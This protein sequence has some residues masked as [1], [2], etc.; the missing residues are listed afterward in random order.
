M[1]ATRTESRPFEQHRFLGRMNL[2]AGTPPS[3]FILYNHVTDY[4]YYGVGGRTFAPMRE[5]LVS[6]LSELGYEIVAIYNS[7]EGMLF[8]EPAMEQRYR[9]VTTG[10]RR[11]NTYG[12]RS[13]TAP[14]TAEAANGTDPGLPQ[15]AL[16]QTGNQIIAGLGA[17]L[18]Q[19][20]R[21]AEQLVRAAVIVERV[22]NLV[23]SPPLPDDRQL[24][25]QLQS[26]SSLTNGNV[27]ILI[28]DVG[29]AEELPAALAGPHRSSVAL[30]DVGLPTQNEINELFTSAR[31]GWLVREF[32]EANRGSPATSITIDQEQHRDLIGRLDR[33]DAV[34]IRGFFNECL[35]QGIPELNMRTLRMITTHTNDVWPTLLDE[36]SLQQIEDGLK[37]KVKGQHFAIQRVVNTLRVVRENL[38][39]QVATG[40]AEEKVLAYF[41]FAGPTGVGKTEVFRVL[42]KV[43]PQIRTRKFNMPEYKEEHSVARF[44]GAP[45]GYVG[46]GKGELGEFLLENPASIILFDEFE[47][48]HPNVWK[49]FLT[50]LEGSLTT[51]DGTRVDLSQTIFIFTSNAG[52]GDLQP[53]YPQMLLGEQ[54]NI[55]NQNRDIVQGALRQQQA[56]PEL[57]GRLLEAIIPFNHLDLRTI[58]DIVKVN[59]QRLSEQTNTRIHESVEAFLLDLYCRHGQFGARM[60]TNHID[61]TLKGDIVRFPAPRGV[62]YKDVDGLTR[63]AQDANAILIPYQ[64]SNAEPQNTTRHQVRIDITSDRTLRDSVAPAIAA[65]LRFDTDGHYRGSG[66][67]FFVS[68]TGYLITNRHVIG[69]CTSIVGVHSGGQMRTDMIIVGVSDYFDLAVLRPAQSLNGGVPYL[70]LANSGS[71]E[72]DTEV[73]TFGY[74]YLEYDDTTERISF[75]A[76]ERSER[77]HIGVRLE[78]EQIFRLSGVGLNSGNSGGPLFACEDGSVIGVIFAKRNAGEGMSYAVMSSVA[79]AFLRD[80][81]IVQPFVRVD[82]S[83]L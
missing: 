4:Y 61:P 43:F 45:P 40:H 6:Y 32:G 15:Q 16:A 2:H 52:A 77:G 67:G 50:M 47:K 72:V 7:S 51:G 55:R 13:G 69:A 54:E 79:Q 17:M 19:S 64:R 26:W 62:I 9:E 3:Q 46:Y 80:M 8:A 38:S 12:R 28:A 71:V 1:V 65:V 75:A 42:A 10:A 27:S 37:N 60:V 35:R 81:G 78:D 39:A 31:S 66:T 23:S 22:Q 76:P 53:I 14:P 21:P 5:T 83:G 34:T 29:R 59:L 68:D 36:S 82:R 74:P 41:F 63:H 11:A 57:I 56:P 30:I 24:L 73:Q 25:D 58:G 44:F 70:T 33:Y 48:A 49:N 18:R 20:G